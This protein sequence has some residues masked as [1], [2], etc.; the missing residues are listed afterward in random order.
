MLFS[1][2]Y[3]ESHPV[4][5]ALLCGGAMGRKDLVPQDSELCMPLDSRDGSQLS[6][7]ESQWWV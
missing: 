4:G 3:P 5:R 7:P 6:N 2:F 1:V